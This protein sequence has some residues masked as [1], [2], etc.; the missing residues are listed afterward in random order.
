MAMHPMMVP[1]RKL[2]SSHKGHSK[3][4]CE[5]TAKR[6]MMQV[7]KLAKGAKFVCHICGRAAAKA[8]NLCEP[9]KL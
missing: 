7:A 3:H 4:L 2:S 8:E 9:V 1:Q 5:L 6:N